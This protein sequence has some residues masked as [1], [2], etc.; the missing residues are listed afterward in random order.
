MKATRL[1][2]L[3]SVNFTE[4]KSNDLLKKSSKNKKTYVKKINMLQNT[5]ETS[6]SENSSNPDN[7]KTK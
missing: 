5:M 1:M 3:F 6:A 2:R 7:E 4:T